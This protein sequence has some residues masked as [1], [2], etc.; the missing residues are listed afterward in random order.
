MAVGELILEEAGQ[1]TG[2]RFSS[3]ESVS[4][5]AMVSIGQHTMPGRTASLQKTL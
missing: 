5:R 2:M 4:V 3:P 1:V